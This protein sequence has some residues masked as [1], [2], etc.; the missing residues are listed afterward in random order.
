MQI[1]DESTCS[2]LVFLIVKIYAFRGNTIWRDS[3]KH[4][5]AHTHCYQP[6]VADSSFQVFVMHIG[7]YKEMK[8]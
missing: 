5:Y 1:R 6:H 2:H 7:T 3:F 8:L 4:T